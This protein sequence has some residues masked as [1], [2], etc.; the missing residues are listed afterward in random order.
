M[1]W[2]KNSPENLMREFEELGP[3]VLFAGVALVTLVLNGFW[4]VHGFQYRGARRRMIKGALCFYFAVPLVSVLL[5]A[6]SVLK[7]PV[8]NC[9][10]PLGSDGRPYGYALFAIIYASLVATIGLI[11]LASASGAKAERPSP[12]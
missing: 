1:R 9:A 3:A 4:I 2:Q 5:F 7:H 10:E 8:A 11:L 12:E 6:L